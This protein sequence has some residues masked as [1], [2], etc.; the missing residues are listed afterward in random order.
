M[1]KVCSG[2]G[3]ELPKDTLT[4]G[5]IEDAIKALNADWEN[6]DGKSLVLRGQKLPVSVVAFHKPESDIF[7]YE[8]GQGIE[9][10]LLCVFSLNGDFYKKTGT[11]D[12]YGTASWD[13]PLRLVQP[14]TKTITVFE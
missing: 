1:S 4:V 13:G 14:T 10:A 2:C 12:S 8:N 9:F 11:A 5:E 3:Q 7:D 6:L